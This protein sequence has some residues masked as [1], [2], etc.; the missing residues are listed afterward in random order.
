MEAN[1]KRDCQRSWLMSM[2]VDAELKS[3]PLMIHNVLVPVFVILVEGVA[4]DFGIYFFSPCVYAAFKGFDVKKTPLSEP[5][6]KAG[7]AFFFPVNKNY[8][9]A[10]AQRVKSLLI[11]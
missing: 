2:G 3:N 11:V 6:L 8:F 4:A 7:T 10:F 5:F 1:G 9:F